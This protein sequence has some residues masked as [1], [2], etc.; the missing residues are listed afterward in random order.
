MT[1]PAASLKGAPSPTVVG[2]SR[3][4]WLDPSKA[5]S[6]SS[7]RRRNASSPRQEP[8][9]KALRSSGDCSIA[10]LNNSFSRLSLAD[11]GVSG[12]E[13]LLPDNRLFRTLNFPEFCMHRKRL[14]TALAEVI[15]WPLGRDRLRGVDDDHGFVQVRS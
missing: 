8:R 2:S 7:T 6:S 9:R 12:G 10:A 13:K 14:R 11:M 5:W 1:A 3:R 4:I 15:D